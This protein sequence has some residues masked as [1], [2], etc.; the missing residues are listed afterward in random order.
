[1]RHR[2]SRTSIRA[3]DRARVE[4]AF[5]LTWRNMWFGSDAKYH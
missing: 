2:Q 5:R 4:E 1:M 3:A